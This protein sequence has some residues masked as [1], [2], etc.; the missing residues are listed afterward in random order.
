[1]LRDLTLNFNSQILIFQYRVYVFSV[2]TTQKQILSCLLCNAS[3]Y[4][5]YIKIN[6]DSVIPVIKR[7]LYTFLE[8]TGR[9]CI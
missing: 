3:L 4:E 2:I 9:K 1:M 8:S 7:K 5:M 6:Y